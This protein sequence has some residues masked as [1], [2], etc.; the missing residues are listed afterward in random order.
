[1]FI[2]F[3]I[4]ITYGCAWMCKDA[5]NQNNQISCNSQTTTK[6]IINNNTQ[7]YKIYIGHN[8][9]KQ[10]RHICKQFFAI[11][12]T[13]KLNRHKENKTK[14]NLICM[15]NYICDICKQFFAT[16]PRFGCLY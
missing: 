15:I 13:T 4:V 11:K 1:M 5:T 7:K 8:L 14:K 16:T 10:K 2:I 12:K 3:I 6:C 9:K